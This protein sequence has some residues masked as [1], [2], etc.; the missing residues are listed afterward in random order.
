MIRG[1]RA[2]PWAGLDIGEYSVKLV[3]IQSGVARQRWASE[4][5]YAPNGNGGSREPTQ[6]A[7][8]VEAAFQAANLSPRSCRG[9]SIGISG[10][11]VILKQVTLPLLDDSEV[12]PALRFEARKHLPFDPQ[13]MIVDYQILG[14]FPSE[15]KL[16]ILLA[17]VSRDHLEA[18]LAPLRM[19]ELEPDIVDAAPLALA[20]ALISIE[21]S[22]GAHVIVDIGEHASHL[23]LVQ[24]GQPFFS[25]RLDFGGHDLTR[26]IADSA[27]I[28][29]EEAEE[30]KLAAGAE[31]PSFR[32]DWNAPELSAVPEVL[33][34]RLV[35]EILRSLAFYRTQATLV[36]LSRLW[37]SGSSAR[38]PGLAARLGE[39]TGLA[40]AVFD[41]LAGA[42]PN[43]TG[44]PQFAQAFGLA[45]RAN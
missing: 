23:V 4:V 11:D 10:P 30:W 41:P 31:R 2:R 44:T 13:T 22:S 17:A 35:D 9:V 6:V 25:R 15:R 29:I 19:L 1:L 45:M 20:N 21:E 18:H 33:R 34:G 12:G 14:R 28:P 36:D 42:D 3:A 16:E 38:L 39:L 24:R 43:V 37:I 8:A 26:A 27:S 40:V 32:V 7:K 5:A